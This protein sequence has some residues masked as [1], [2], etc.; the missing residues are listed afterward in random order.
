M[1]WKDAYRSMKIKFHKS[2]ESLSLRQSGELRKRQDAS[3][4][5]TAAVSSIA[6][7]VPPSSQPT[8]VIN[9]VHKNIDI[10]FQNTQILPPNFPG[11]NSVTLHGPLV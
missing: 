5:A 3:P 11:V 1:H 4:T 9:Q 6:F 8:P 7:P 2:D 10:S